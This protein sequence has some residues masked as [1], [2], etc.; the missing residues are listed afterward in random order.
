MSEA[1]AMRKLTN[2]TYITLDGVIQD[3]QD[4]PSLGSGDER[5]LTIQ[6]ELLLSCEVQIMGRRT[7]EGFAAVWPTRSG[8]PY[9][10]HIN[11][12]RKL[13]FSSQV[14]EPS[15]N[16]TVAVVE[17]PVQ[18]VRDLKAQDGGDIVQYGFGHLAHELLAAGL[19]DE[20]RLWV[21]PF[22]IGHG[23][24]QALLYRDSTT[25]R[26]N[27]VATTALENGI[28]ILTYNKA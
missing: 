11:A 10:D 16:N 6:T 8:D 25:T 2:S 5:G 15:W 13:L 3:P 18:A 23:G 22:L 1:D 7:Y 28:V 14:A 19:M 21:H 27:L 24:P 20:L 26:L 17:D 4:W 12:M 9:S